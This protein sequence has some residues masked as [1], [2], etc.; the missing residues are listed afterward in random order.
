MK[1]NTQLNLLPDVPPLGPRLIAIKAR[2]YRER[3]LEELRNHAPAWATCWAQNASGSG[4]YWEHT[5]TADMLSGY[6]VAPPEC[7]RHQCHSLRRDMML[8]GDWSQLLFFAN[9]FQ[10]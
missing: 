10:P 6:W 9:E 3:V 5:P 2:S 7:H 1:A 8:R 4:Y